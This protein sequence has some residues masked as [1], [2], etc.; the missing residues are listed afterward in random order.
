M[1]RM[2]SPCIMPTWV[3]ATTISNVSNAKHS[4]H[5]N[6]PAASSASP[7]TPHRAARAVPHR[8]PV[9]LQ[10]IDVPPSAVTLAICCSGGIWPRSSGSMGASPTSL[11]ASSAARISSVF[12]WV[13][14]WT[15]RRTRRSVPACLRV[16]REH[17]APDC[18]L[19]LLTAIVRPSTALASRR[20][21]P[22]HGGIKPDRQR[23]TA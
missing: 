3:P 12:S 4:G 15:L 8:A 11:V 21:L 9:G 19:I 10:R 14:M 23:P 5:L 13:P 22:G 1:S 17:R 7:E 2:P 20:G 18:F 6:R 16:R